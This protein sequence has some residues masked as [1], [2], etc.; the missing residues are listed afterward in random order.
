M[1]SIHK[2]TTGFFFKTVAKSLFILKNNTTYSHYLRN[3]PE[4]NVY[5]PTTQVLPTS[6]HL[7]LSTCLGSTLQSIDASGTQLTDQNLFFITSTFFNLHK[8][9]LLILNWVCGSLGRLSNS[10][11]FSQDK[12]FFNYWWLEREIGE[13]VGVFFEHKEDTRNLLLEYMNVFRPLLKLFPVCGVL[14][15]FFDTIAQ[16]IHHREQ[17]VQL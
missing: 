16:T 3:T 14:E 12:V 1:L 9:F 15:L 11:T 10:I 17:T 5:V 6:L 13:M 8:G 7:K 2:N 4:L